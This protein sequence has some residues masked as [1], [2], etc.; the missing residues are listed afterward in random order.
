MGFRTQQGKPIPENTTDHLIL[1]KW[2]RE[3]KVLD[4]YVIDEDV[5]A[6]LAGITAQEE[7][8]IVNLSRAQRAFLR[9][10]K[11]FSEIHGKNPIP[12][13]TVKDHCVLQ[14][15]GLLKGDRLADQVLEPLEVGGWLTRPS[16]SGEGRGAKS[17]RVAATDKLVGLKPEY[18]KAERSGG[19]PPEVRD[20]LNTPLE[21]IVRDLA[22]EDTHIKG[23]A[24]EVLSVRLAYE[25]GLT[26]LRFRERGRE[27]QGAEV[28]MIAEG[29]HLHFSRW[30]F[31]CKNTRT[32]S[33]AALAKE[34]GMA[35]LLKAHV[36]VLVTTG[37][38]AETVREHADGL[39][40]TTPLQVVLI[41][42]EVLKQYQER[43]ATYLVHHFRTTA[44]GTMRLK[45]RQV[46]SEDQ[47]GAEASSPSQSQ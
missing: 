34:I 41:D 43:G 46:S 45:R 35:V 12:A 4:K 20:K 19:I 40:E 42:G 22:L 24:L 15:P 10:L 37:R 7:K 2:L 21:E 38:F 9:V 3:A 16:S 28:D 25:L 33:L 26:P 23:L 44:E 1:L 11:D 27:T 32:V 13:K 36:I 30:L 31:Q 14:Y 6:R 5:F 18:L 29:I 39:A 8:E 17:G 47:P